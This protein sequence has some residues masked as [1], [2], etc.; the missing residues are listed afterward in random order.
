MHDVPQDRSYAT[1]GNT[2]LVAG[3]YAAP[4]SPHRTDPDGVLSTTPTLT[5]T[6]LGPFASANGGTVTMKADGSFSYVPPAGF[7]GSDTSASGSCFS[8]R[9][10]VM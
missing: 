10:R 4:A 3:S 1:T 9:Q 7:T 8:S 2:E 5:V 6:S